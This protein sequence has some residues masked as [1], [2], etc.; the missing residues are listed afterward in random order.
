MLWTRRSEY[1]NGH[2]CRS[3]MSA[4]K[5]NNHRRYHISII[6]DIYDQALASAPWPSPIRVPSL[7]H[8]VWQWPPPLPCLCII[9]YGKGG[10]PILFNGRGVCTVFFLKQPPLGMAVA[11]LTAAFVQYST[12]GCVFP[13]NYNKLA[14]D[15]GMRARSY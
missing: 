12:I 14:F 10:F 5:K 4:P 3:Y 13:N 6:V 15:L 7:N 1:G 8:W 11:S 9:G 2:I